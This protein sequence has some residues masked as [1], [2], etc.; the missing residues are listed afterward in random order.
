[1]SK[2]HERKKQAAKMFVENSQRNA[3]T[4]CNVSSRCL[5]DTNWVFSFYELFSTPTVSIFGRILSSEKSLSK[6]VV[7]V[8]VS[9][10]VCVCVS[11]FCL[12]TNQQHQLDENGVFSFFS[13]TLLHSAP[14][15]CESLCVWESERAF[16]C[17][18]VWVCASVLQP[19]E[20]VCEQRSKM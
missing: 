17:V 7:V 20:L 4:K 19:I 18:C 10:C 8:V 2:N 5:I 6:V 9:V 11:A 15:V 3:R 16:V 12:H 1:M 14:F 13:A